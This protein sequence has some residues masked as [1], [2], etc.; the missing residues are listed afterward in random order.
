MSDCLVQETY[1][2]QLGFR[3]QINCS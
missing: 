3:D 2:K 1:E